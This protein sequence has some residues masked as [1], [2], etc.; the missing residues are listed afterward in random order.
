MAVVLDSEFGMTDCK[1]SNHAIVYK[2][3]AYAYWNVMVR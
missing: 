1:R 2:G 3:V